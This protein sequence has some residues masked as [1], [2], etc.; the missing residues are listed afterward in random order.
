MSKDMLIGVV[1]PCKSGKT[2]L[3]DGLENHGYRCRHIAQEHSASPSMWQKMTNPDVLIYLDVSYSETLRRGQPD[4]T[5]KDYR[6][7]QRRLAHA[8]QHADLYIDTNTTEREEVL[9][10]ALRYLQQKSG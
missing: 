3:I 10:A 5:E 6:E 1:G 9:N 8:R 7:E 4:W 2:T